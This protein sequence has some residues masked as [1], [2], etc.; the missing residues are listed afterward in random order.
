MLE[1]FHLLHDFHRLHIFNVNQTECC[2][3]YAIVFEVL[4]IKRLNV[5]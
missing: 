1:L 4:E 5:L 2:N 3:V